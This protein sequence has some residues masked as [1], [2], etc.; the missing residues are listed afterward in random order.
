[1]FIAWRYALQPR[2]AMPAMPREKAIKVICSAGAELFLETLR[3][4][5]FA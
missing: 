5:P 3:A 1:M 4:K 2:N